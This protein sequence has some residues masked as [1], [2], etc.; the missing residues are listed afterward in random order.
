MGLGDSRDDTK[1]CFNPQKSYELGWYS[2]KVETIYPLDGTDTFEYVLNGVADYEGNEDALVVLRLMQTRSTHKNLDYFIGYN[3]AKGI[4]KDTDA[5][6]NKVTITYTNSSDG[7]FGG[8]SQSWKIASLSPGQWYE[9]ENYDGLRS[10]SVQFS[11][12]VS[13][14]DAG[15]KIIDGPPD[16]G[17]SGE[18]MEIFVEVTT[19]KFPGE[20]VWTVLYNSHDYRFAYSFSDYTDQYTTTT[21]EVCLPMGET[22]RQFKFQMEDDYGDGL[23]CQQGGEG[24]YKVSDED[25]NVLFSVSDDYQFSTETHYISVPKAFSDDECTDD[26]DFRHNDI[27]KRSCAWVGKNAGNRCALDDGEVS[28]ACPA[29]C[30]PACS[31]GCSDNEAFRQAGI[32]KRS[33]DW[34]V[35]NAEQ[36]CALDDGETVHECAATYN[37]ACRCKDDPNYLHNEVE[38]RDCE[39]AS[40]NTEKRCPIKNNEVFNACR[41]TCDPTCSP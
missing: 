33:C 20:I 30:N 27:D 13:N 28:T 26:P 29:T 8:V 11:Y 38:G 34:V 40:R 12:L 36:R 2:D 18:C 35:K 31:N 32:A 10:V 9:I 14:T 23:C 22:E 7:A 37:P 17:P 41:K 39:W 3:R 6:E 19:D 21:E 1:Q 24:G 5:D 25:G 15:I 16:P 4:N